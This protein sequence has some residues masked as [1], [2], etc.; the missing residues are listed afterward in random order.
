M[1]TWKKAAA[2]V[3]AG[4][5]SAGLLAGCGST[6]LD[7]SETLL[8]VNDESVDLGVGSFY[9]KFQQAQMFTYWGSYF[10]QNG[11][12]DT[13]TD[14]ES[15]KSYGEQLKDGVI[16]DLTKMILLS[17]HAS[18]YNVALTD[19]QKTAISEAAQAYVDANDQETLDK[20]GATKEDVE[21]LMTL[22]TIQSL[23]MDPIVADVDTDIPDEEVQQSSVTYVE[24]EVKQDEEN[25]DTAEGEAAAEDAENADAAE[26][27]AAAEDA[28][29]AD[30]AE[31]DAAAEDA[32]NADT[33]EADAAA[34]ETEPAA[35]DDA[36]EAAKADAQAILDKLLAAEDPATADVSALA[37]EVNEEYN[38]FTGSFTVSDHT[39]TTLDAKVVEAVADLKDGEVVKEPVISDDGQSFYVVRMDKVFDQDATDTERKS[40]I[41]DRK[42][43]K[44]D[45]VTDGWVEEA[46]D[47]TT[48]NDKAWAK[49][50]ITDQ[51]P[52]MLKLPAPEETTEDEDASEQHEKE[53][54]VSDNAAAETSD[55]AEA[56]EETAESAE[57]EAAE[58][59]ATEGEAAEAEATEGEAAEA[60]A[61]GGEATEG[62]ATEETTDAAEG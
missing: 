33:A 59:E 55:T 21:K 48:V 3:L 32:E 18:E 34:E 6:K 43:D 26:G 2:L 40:R 35:S 45:E 52:F 24:V 46:K 44:Y 60:D 5:M 51:E 13:V 49:V 11:M 53:E 29:N 20:I 56:S 25:A 28:E 54:E 38:S 31:A 15:G 41:I 27:D 47:K 7:G 22:Q 30:A 61:V 19:E 9:A 1:H 4:V 36:V 16:S 8:T 42:Q 58:A 62:E 12:F 10:G 39:D 14:D 57:G 37:K 50:K 17:Q 23:M